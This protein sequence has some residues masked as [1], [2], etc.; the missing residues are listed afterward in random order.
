VTKKL[1]EILIE[2]GEETPIRD[3]PDLD[4]AVLRSAGNDIVVERIPFD[5]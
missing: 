3:V 5:V 1:Y 2:V 4:G